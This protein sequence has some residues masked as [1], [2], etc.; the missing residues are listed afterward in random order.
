V[1]SDKLY[2]VTLNEAEIGLLMDKL[3]CSVIAGDDSR[4]EIIP[5]GPIATAPELLAMLT[6]V[7]TET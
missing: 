4:Y 6:A 5:D 7:K 3:L 2:H 1:K